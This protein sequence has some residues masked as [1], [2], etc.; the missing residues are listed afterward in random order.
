[1]PDDTSLKASVVAPHDRQLGGLLRHPSERLQAAAIRAYE[2]HQCLPRRVDELERF[3]HAAEVGAEEV[4]EAATDTL[5]TLLPMVG[6]PSTHG[7]ARSANTSLGSAFS[8]RGLPNGNELSR[9]ELA[10]LRAASYREP[11][12]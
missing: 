6:V 1:M 11:I 12:S 5:L 8:T 3:L 4:R 9:E 7:G 10:H 2:A